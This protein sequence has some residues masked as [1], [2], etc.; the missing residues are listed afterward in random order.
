MNTRLVLILLYPALVLAAA[1]GSLLCLHYLQGSA[2]VPAAVSSAPS[3]RHVDSLPADNIV[4]DSDERRQ[5]WEAR[6]A[7]DAAAKPAK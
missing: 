4:W 6:K 1:L 2:Q 5:A 3:A 7:Q